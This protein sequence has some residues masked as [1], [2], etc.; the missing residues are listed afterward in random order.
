MDFF[1]TSLEEVRE[2]E[3][4]AREKFPQRGIYL[5]ESALRTRNSTHWLG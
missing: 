5:Y 1:H 2:A 4:K 3:V